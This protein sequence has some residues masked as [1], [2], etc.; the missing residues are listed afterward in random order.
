MK[1]NRFEGG[2]SWRREIEM[3]R[4]EVEEFELVSGS[5]VR[6]ELVATSARVIG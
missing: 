1:I 5:V 6:I 2:G 3:N 4:G